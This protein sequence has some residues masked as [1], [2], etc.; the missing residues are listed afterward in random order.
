MSERPRAYWRPAEAR[1]SLLQPLSVGVG[2][3]GRRPR[4]L[5]RAEAPS[6]AAHSYPRSDSH[7]ATAGRDVFLL[8]RRVI[9]CY[10]GRKEGGGQID[11]SSG[12]EREGKEEEEGAEI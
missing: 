11:Y 2:S 5:L 1:H 12:R 3:D 6:G 4:L 9:V 7:S 10:S 8:P